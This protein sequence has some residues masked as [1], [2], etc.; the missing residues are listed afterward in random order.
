NNES[1]AQTDLV[2]WANLGTHHIPRAEDAP[3]TLTNVATS[4]LLLSP[5]NFNDHD[6]AMECVLSQHPADTLADRATRSC[7]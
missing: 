5:W 7:S 3:N 4:Y 2:V 1:L 6:V